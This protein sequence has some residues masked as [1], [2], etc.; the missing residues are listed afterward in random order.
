MR[1][2]IQPE[3]EVFKNQNRFQKKLINFLLSRTKNKSDL[4]SQKVM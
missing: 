4:L 2:E 1:D 3:F